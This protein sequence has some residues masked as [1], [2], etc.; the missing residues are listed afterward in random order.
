MGTK[1]T[2]QTS[3]EGP[4]DLQAIADQI[5]DVADEL[6]AVAE[7]MR[8]KGIPAI[9]VR[10]GPGLRTAIRDSLVPYAQDARKKADREIKRKESRR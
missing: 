2:R 10:Y 1:G 8:L 4:G 3:D 5:R 9:T 7:D 6:A